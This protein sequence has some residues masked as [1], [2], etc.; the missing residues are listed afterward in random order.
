MKKEYT[1]PSIEIEKLNFEDVILTSGTT[2][3]S[4]IVLLRT[5]VS[6]SDFKSNIIENI[7]FTFTIA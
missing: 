1:M 6:M 4:T 3:E 2:G 5:K 7:D